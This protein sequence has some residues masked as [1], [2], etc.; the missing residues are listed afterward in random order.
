MLVLKRRMPSWMLPNMPIKPPTEEIIHTEWDDVEII[1]Q[2]EPD[3]IIIHNSAFYFSTTTDDP[4]KKLSSFLLS[5]EN[6][7]TKFLIYSRADAF[8][9][10]EALKQY[11]ENNFP[12]LKGRV[13]VLWVPNGE[14]Q[15]WAVSLLRAVNISKG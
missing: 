2:S 10:E 9:D 7:K 8:E 3:L 5:M 15:N 13:E 12:F 4:E 1:S 11:F 14:S 6:T